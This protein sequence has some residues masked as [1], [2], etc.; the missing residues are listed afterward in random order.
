MGKKRTMSLSKC[1]LLTRG[2]CTFC[3]IGLMA[4][5]KHQKRSVFFEIELIILD[6]IFLF[7]FVYLFIFILYFCCSFD[8]MIPQC[9][10]SIL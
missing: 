2:L 10:V 9:K 4:D 7:L 8:L 5:A 3:D 1:E 6:R